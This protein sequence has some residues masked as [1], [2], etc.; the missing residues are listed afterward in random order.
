MRAIREQVASAIDLVVQQQRFKDGTRHIT[1]ISE[2][3]GMEGDVIT[4]QDVFVFD[5][6]PGFDESGRSLG[7]LRSTGLRPKF[8][9]KLAASGVTLPAEVF[10][11]PKAARR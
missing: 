6:G 8:V 2:V 9:D 3:V 1:H 10:A 5:H 7:F 11:M 4:M